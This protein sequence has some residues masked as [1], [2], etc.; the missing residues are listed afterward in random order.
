M[1]TTRKLKSHNDLDGVTPGILAK[2]AFGEDIDVMYCS[3]NGIDKAVERFFEKAENEEVMLYITDISVNDENAQRLQQ[4]YKRHGGVCLIDHHISADH[5]NQYSWAT[6]QATYEDGR[7][8]SA[9]SL[10]YEYLVREGALKETKALQQFVELVRSYD[11][12]EW[13]EAGNVQAK[14]LNDLFYIVGI[15]AFEQTMINRLTEHPEGFFFDETEQTILAME[16][17]KINRFI[18]Q[19]QKQIVETYVDPYYVGIVHAEQYHS[20]LGNALG[21][22]NPHLDA[23][24]IVNLGG[25]KLSFRTI[26]DEVNVSSF[27]KTFG[28]GGHIKASG[29]PLTQE[30]LETFV[31]APFPLLPRKQDPEKNKYNTKE[32]PYGVVYENEAGEY[33]WIFPVGEKWQVRHEESGEVCIFD[34]YEEAE[35]CVKRK[36]K[37]WLSMDDVLIEKYV[38]KFG[39]K[40]ATLRSQFEKT[41]KE[42]V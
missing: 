26:H 37:A 28:G 10:F 4:H 24:A 42:L 2:L 16:E 18:A 12:W 25:K 23:I 36:P 3:T 32:S 41:M 13:N 21:E 1:K 5:L 38:E 30:T 6:V 33:H 7:K 14:Q 9:A 35:N 27:A 11:T 8:T 20:E 31:I 34:S 19:K 40:E 29:A 17:D 39:V 22:L 15:E